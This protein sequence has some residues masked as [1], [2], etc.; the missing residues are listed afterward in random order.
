MVS[1]PG[2]LAPEGT[3]LAVVEGST[4]LPNVDNAAEFDQAVLPFFVV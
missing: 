4:R 1:F 3:R 2:L